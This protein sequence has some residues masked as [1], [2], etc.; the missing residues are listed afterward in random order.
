MRGYLE[1]RGQRLERP[2]LYGHWD[3]A[4]YAELEGGRVVELWR[5]SP[6][7]PEPTRYNLTKFAIE[8]NELTPG[9]EYKVA[10][11]DCRLRPDQAFTERGM[12]DEANAEKQRLEHKQRAARRAAD[13]GDPLEPRWF[14]MLP[15]GAAGKVRGPDELAFRYRLG[16]WEERAAGA[17]T[18]CRDIFGPLVE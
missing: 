16:Y 14:E 18:G 5:K 6:P 17:F 11:T 4:M 12:W 9:L 2:L 7:P 8:L 1:R 13:R 15:A 10:P 3:D